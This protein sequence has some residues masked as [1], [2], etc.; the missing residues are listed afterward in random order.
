MQ[1]LDPRDRDLLCALQVE[2]PLYST[3]YALIGQ[4]IDMSEKEVIKRAERL[5]REGALKQISGSFDPRALGYRSTLV[6]ARIPAD[7]I[8]RAAS[9]INLH[10]GVSQN[11]RRNH[12]FNLWFSIAV[13][14]STRLGLQ[15]V[16]SILSEEAGCEVVR[17]L[18]MLKHYRAGTEPERG[19]EVDAHPSDTAAALS[20]NE[21]E[22]IKLLQNDFPLQPRPF[23]VLSKTSGIDGDELLTTAQRL[24]ARGQLKK[25]AAVLQIRRSS[26]NANA[27]GVWVVPSDRVDEVASAMVTN[28]AVL[29]CFLRPTYEDWPYNIFTTV[30]ARSTDEC[31]SILSDLARQ[32]S[33]N[34]MRALYPTK[35]YKSSRLA[36]FSEDNAEWEASRLDSAER[37]QTAAN[38][39]S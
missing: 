20:T 18:P 23:E 17:L 3:P 2:L 25:L 19:N 11:Y 27:M 39:A 24:K 5:K 6:A 22:V 28:K 10:P 16:V 4:Q 8:D 35:E 31:D 30:Q 13:P 7:N 9:A 38:A 1:E 33:L 32:T 15:Q 36:L 29:Q 34:E 14:P 37:S 26:F 21:I 12:D